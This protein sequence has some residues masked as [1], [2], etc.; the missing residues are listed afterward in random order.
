MTN[1]DKARQGWPET[2]TCVHCRREIPPDEVLHPE[3]ADYTLAFCSADCHA[4]WREGQ[5]RQDG[6]SGGN[7]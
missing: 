3:G 7:G 4:L 6:E 2:F 5:R 1:D